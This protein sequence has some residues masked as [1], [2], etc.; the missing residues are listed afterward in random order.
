MSQNQDFSESH[1]QPYRNETPQHRQPIG[2][3]QGSAVRQ[4]LLFQE[5]LRLLK[6]TQYQEAIALFNKVLEIQPDCYQA[7]YYH[8]L[9]LHHLGCHNE[10]VASYNK[11]IEFNPNYH[12]AWSDLSYALSILGRYKLALATCNKALEIQPDYCQAWFRRGFILKKLGRG[13]EALASCNKALEIQPD[14]PEAWNTRSL[15]LE[16]SNHHKEALADLEKALEIQPDYHKAWFNRGIVLLKLGRKEE[17]LASFQKAL[18][19]QRGYQEWYHQA[20]YGHGFILARLGRHQEAIVS[21]EKSLEIKPTPAAALSNLVSLLL[22]GKFFTYLATPQKRVKLLKALRIIFDRLKF[23]LLFLIVVYLV[24][25]YGHG[26]WTHL[27]KEAVST[28][29]SALIVLLILRELWDNKSKLNLIWQV[30]FKSGILTYLRAFT[31]ATITLTSF[32]VVAPNVPPFLT[33]GW[34]SMVF[35]NSGNVIFQPLNTIQKVKPSTTEDVV[36]PSPSIDKTGSSSPSE[37]A[38]IQD[39]TSVP[40]KIASQ[41]ASVSQKASFDYSLI[42][43]T[44][45]WMLLILVVPFWAGLEEKI[46]RQGANSWKQIIIKSTLFGL[47][48][49]TVGIPLF[50]G[51]I[52]IIPGFLFACRYKYVHDK[53]LRKTNDE[54]A[55]QEAG[56]AASTADHAIYNAILIT[57][58]I[59]VMLLPK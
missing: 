3:E 29:F 17:A 11:A 6:H 38:P 12:E 18:H 37:K 16:L 13:P 54:Q 15:V 35:G 45:F 48:H 42:L 55:A 51:F 24:L 47:V 22:S 39:A 25:T 34:G 7:W 58:A 44:L 10:A 43:I 28:I 26:A 19:I 41:P 33:W 2:H 57:L 8:G 21:F 46:F 20:W 36:T 31:I 59:A 53:H 4:A 50:A 23:F 32:A 1:E 56:V 49:I 27:F 14:N 5:G 40:E 52:I 9:A 30:Y